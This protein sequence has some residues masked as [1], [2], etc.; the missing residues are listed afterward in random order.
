LFKKPVEIRAARIGTCY[1]S[2]KRMLKYDTIV[3]DLNRLPNGAV[4]MVDGKATLKLR[5]DSSISKN[6]Q[7][8]FFSVT[9]GRN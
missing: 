8:T 2:V 4:I 3:F 6:A 7:D 1:D 5:A 9:G